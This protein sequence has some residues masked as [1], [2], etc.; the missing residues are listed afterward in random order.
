VI[1]DVVFF[2][3]DSSF[4][5][6][7]IAFMTKSDYSHVG[8]IV[9]YDEL[10]RMATIIESD[11]FVNTRINRLELDEKHVVYTTGDKPKEQVD[12]I[13]KFANQ[14]L[15]VKYDYLQI[16]GLFLSLLFKGE[17]YF[18][19][20]NRFICSE[21]IDI[22]YYKAGVERLTDINIG[23]ISPQELLEVYE[24]RVRKGV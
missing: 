3:K 13:L 20:A 2:R 12:R 10:T 8:I 4:I 19:S 18:N 7:M 11:R 22:A 17:R 9:A 21:L 6:R 14:A 15:G 5:S 1:G 23:N 16:L 24:F